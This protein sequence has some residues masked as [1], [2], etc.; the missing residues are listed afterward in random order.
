MESFSKLKLFLWTSIGCAVIAQLLFINNWVYPGLILYGIAAVLWVRTMGNQS[1]QFKLQGNILTKKHAFMLL[2][3][4]MVIAGFFRFYCLDS[5]PPKLWQD[6]RAHLVDAQQILNGQ[7]TIF[8]PANN[9]RESLYIYLIA[10]SVKLFGEHN[11]VVR[12][13][14]ALIGTLSILLF[15]L[16]IRRLFNRDIAI[17]SSIALAC[18]AWHIIMSHVAYRLILTIPFM[19]AALIFLLKFRQTGKLKHIIISAVISGVGLY[20]YSTFRFA[21]PVIIF[22]WTCLIVKN[23]EWNRKQLAAFMI[24]CVI[25]G[26]IALPLLHYALTHRK[27]FHRRWFQVSAMHC[28]NSVQKVTECTINTMLMANYKGCCYKKYN[29]P[30]RPVL[31]WF[32]SFFFPLGAVMFVRSIKVQSSHLLILFWLFFGLLPGMIT[33]PS[34]WFSRQILALPGILLITMTALYTFFLIA[35]KSQEEKRRRCLFFALVFCL[36]LVWSATTYQNIFKHWANVVK[37]TRK[38]DLIS[39]CHME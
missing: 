10:F 32:L 18:N 25:V 34:P 11:W 6:E 14:G 1:I 29:I 3:V 24:Y 20:T 15:Y 26:I 22:F 17:L 5:L 33:Y 2:L 39:V 37:P 7:H 38:A 21:L 36:L 23:A 28:E 9:G 27:A 4:I 35:V 16:L 19:C 8:C 12:F 31:P 30:D 13:P